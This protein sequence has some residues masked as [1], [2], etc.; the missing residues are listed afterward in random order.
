MYGHD[1]VTF[2]NCRFV[3]CNMYRRN[4]VGYGNNSSFI[5]CQFIRTVATIQ[6]DTDMALT[7]DNDN[8]NGLDTWHSKNYS[9]SQSLTILF[10]NCL[11]YNN[12]GGHL[13]YI[14]GGSSNTN[15]QVLIFDSCNFWTSDSGKSAICVDGGTA[16][17]NYL[18]QNN[19]SNVGTS[20]INSGVLTNSLSGT[21]FQVISSFSIPAIL[22]K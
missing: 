17:Y 14:R 20:T 22:Y 15:N 2:K 3:N 18:L 1:N 13:L 11:F 21:G 4:I 5:D 9:A 19:L 16:S 8:G 12:V 10:K 6:Y 7:S